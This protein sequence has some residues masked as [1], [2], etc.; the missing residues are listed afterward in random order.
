MHETLT[1]ITWWPPRAIPEDKKN[2]IRAALN[3]EKGLNYTSTDPYFFGKQVAR[4]AEL[5][6]VA[7]NLGETA[8][9][10]EIRN[11]M[12][13]YLEPW[14]E[15]KNVDYLV[16]DSTWKGLCSSKG[17]E[18]S[19]ADF[20]QGWYNDHHFHYG[21]FMFAAATIGKEDS[22]W[23]TKYSSA[24]LSFVRD[25]ANPSINDPY[26]TYSRHKDWYDGHSWAAGLYEFADAR[27]QESSSEAINAYYGLYLLGNALK[28]TDL[29]N[30]GKLMLASEIR[31]AKKYWHIKSCDNI[32]AEEFKVNKVV[33]V[34][35]STKVDYATFFGANVEYIHGI[36][37]I[38]FT[39]ITEEYLTN[40]WI[41]EEYPVVS[42]ALSSG[43]LEEGWRGFIYM[44]HSILS[45]DQAWNEVKTLKSYDDG[46]TKTNTLYWVATRP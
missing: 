32:Y 14:F 29:E 42:T 44:A 25:Y 7:D 11:R 23:L 9:A 46:N 3:E 27:N 33:G 40:D 5:A 15:A 22:A 1:S 18:D 12:K 13:T 36:Q 34:L 16:F 38:P 6:L 30:F 19:G 37:Y 20:G 41:L 8:I 17:M 31:S 39:P 28:N 21:Y 26:F 10:T 2:D 24:I 45:K 43:G 35:W 4:L